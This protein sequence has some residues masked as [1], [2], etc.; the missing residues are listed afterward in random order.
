MLVLT[1]LAE[2]TPTQ[3]PDGLPQ[4]DISVKTLKNPNEH[5][6]ATKNIMRLN[7]TTRRYNL[8]MISNNQYYLSI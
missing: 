3:K 5:I 4:V 8:A 7:L 1:A 2:E 6:F